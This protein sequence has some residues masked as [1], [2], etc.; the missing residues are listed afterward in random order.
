MVIVVVAVVGEDDGNNNDQCGGCVVG[1]C[2][3][4]SLCVFKFWIHKINKIIKLIV[5]S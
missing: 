4:S 2:S 3:E 5:G 1:G